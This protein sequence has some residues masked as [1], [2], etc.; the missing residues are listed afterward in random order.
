MS[1]ASTLESLFLQVQAMRAC[2]DCED[3]VGTGRLLILHDQELRRFLADPAAAAAHVE[4]LGELLAAQHAVTELMVA[5]R[6][7][8]R[9]QMQA[10]RQNGVA[11]HAY[12]A[13][14]G[15]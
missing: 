5:A 3:T 14:A 4:A 2:L 7:G 15:G 13:N 11:T 6:E 8:A 12:L 9:R 1:A 10:T